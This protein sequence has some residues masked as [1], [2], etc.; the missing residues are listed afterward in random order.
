MRALLATAALFLALA[1]LPLLVHDVFYQRVSALVL[2]GAI[3]ASAWNL[4]GGFSGYLSLGHV[5]ALYKP[6][7]VGGIFLDSGALDTLTSGR[8]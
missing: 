8:S 4:I 3:S 7:F 2:L 1:A 6:P 5:H